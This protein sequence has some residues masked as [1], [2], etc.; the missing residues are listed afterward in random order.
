MPAIE[1]FFST[2]SPYSYLAG[3][4]FREICDRHGAEV[5]FKPLDLAGLFPRTG[6]FALPDRH[7]SR[8][9]YRLVDLARQARKAGLPIN[10]EPAH[11]PTNP[12]PSSYAI[13]AAQA[14]GG[15]D[16]FG[17][18]ER[19]LAGCWAEEKNI[20]DDSV[21]RDCLSASGF[22]PA[23]VDRGLFTGAEIYA[24]NLEEAVT[25]GVFGAPTWIVDGAEQFWGQD[26]VEDLG[27]YLEGAL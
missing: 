5:S 7:P 17:L 3:P 14:E 21:I 16:M 19:V 9:A 25:A 13:I 27:L 18:V 4:R 20:A 23:L 11:F 8:L 10:V 26:R 12:A 2:V 15:G 6:G 22:D 1:Y 24:R